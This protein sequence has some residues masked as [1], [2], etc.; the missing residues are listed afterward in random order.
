MMRSNRSDGIWKPIL[1]NPLTILKATF[2]ILLITAVSALSGC[3]SDTQIERDN[4]E[5][6]TLDNG[7]EVAVITNELAP[8]VT[9]M[10]WYKIGSADE[11]TGKSGIAHL[12]EHL[13]FKATKTRP[14]GA[15]SKTVASLGGQDN[16]FT[17][18]D[19]TGYFER[20]AKHQLDAVMQLEADRMTGLQLTPE[21]VKTEKLVVLEE[22]SMRTDSRP[23]SLLGEQMRAAL[24][25]GHPYAIPVIGW[26]KEIEALEHADA[27]AFYK[28]HYA[29]DNAILLVVGD[30]TMAD[31]LPLAKKYFG[32]IAASGKQRP[33]RPQID[34][35][36]ARLSPETIIVSDGRAQQKVWQRLYR[37]PDLDDIS[38]EDRAAL[39]ILIQM[40]G[41][42]TTSHLYQSLVATDRMAA[43]IAS[44]ADIMRIGV[45]EIGIYAIASQG[46]DLETLG[47][48]IDAQIQIFQETAIN[49]DALERS[50]TQFR[51]SFLF[52]QDSQHNLAQS[53]GTALVLGNQPS[54]IKD[55]PARIKAV[56]AIDVQNAA[57]RFLQKQHS[58][59]GHLKP[60]GK[61]Q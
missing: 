55:W 6:A 46:M 15:F 37:L 59:T 19:Y 28:A 5:F 22:R 40:L 61:S 13:M 4:I 50:K 57:R 10:L 35:E 39:T 43:T 3:S 23:M 38:Q 34:F 7:M 29:P 44:W 8:T 45:G 25:S 11:P 24:Y 18:Y 36:A 30:V 51:A 52:G 49:E 1:D 20:V 54:D 14:D 31:V 9:Q 21:D 16:A 58:V 27:V 32:P 42:D 33:E 41:G 56:K 53:Y 12:F 47:R 48:A 60:E 17:S 2:I 26:R